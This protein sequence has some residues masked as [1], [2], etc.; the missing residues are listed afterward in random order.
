[1]MTDQHAHSERLADLAEWLAYA[2]QWLEV[3]VQES[4]TM[5]PADCSFPPEQRIENVAFISAEL[6]AM[7]VGC[8]R[9]SAILRAMSPCS[10]TSQDHARAIRRQPYHLRLVK[11]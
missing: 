8:R 9:A 2:S 7:V 11:G 4:R 3:E 10:P 1:M 5:R 6:D